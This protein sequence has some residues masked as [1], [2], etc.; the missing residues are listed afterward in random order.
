[1]VIATL[2]FFASSIAALASDKPKMATEIPV[3]ITA[4]AEV[5]TRIGALRTQD[6]FPDKATIE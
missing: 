1:M 3:G 5:N 6:G 2:A 4:P